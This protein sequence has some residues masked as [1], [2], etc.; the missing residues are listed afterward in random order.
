MTKSDK[1]QNNTIHPGS[2]KGAV[3]KGPVHE[4]SSELMETIPG[5]HPEDVTDVPQSG[6]LAALLMSYGAQPVSGP[7]E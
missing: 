4:K 5:S 6:G 7:T 2:R 3:A 1:V